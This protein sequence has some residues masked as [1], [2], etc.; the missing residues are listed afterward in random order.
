MKLKESVFVSLIIALFP[1]IGDSLKTY[2]Y[3]FFRE[4]SKNREHDIKLNGKDV[5]IK[6]HEEIASLFFKDYNYEIYLINKHF[7]ININDIVVTGIYSDNCFF[8]TSVWNKQFK[9]VMHL[10]KKINNNLL[11]KLVYSEIDYSMDRNLFEILCY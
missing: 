6:I 3:F 9:K 4:L 5:K 1:D 7:K 2:F 11:Y 10:N 8:I